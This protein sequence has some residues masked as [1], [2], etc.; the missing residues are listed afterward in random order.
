[1]LVYQSNAEGVD[2]FSYVNTFFAHWVIMSARFLN[3]INTDF[4]FKIGNLSTSVFN[5]LPRK[6]LHISRRNLHKAFKCHF[7]PL[8]I[9]SSL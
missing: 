2:V 7:N 8:R 3:A 1:M 6:V 9:R 4:E 5:K